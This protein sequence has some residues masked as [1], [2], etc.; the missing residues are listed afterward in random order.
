MQKFWKLLFIGRFVNSGC[1]ILTHPTANMFALQL[2]WL[3]LAF[4]LSVAIVLA[5][6]LVH[7]EWNGW[8]PLLQIYY[9]QLRW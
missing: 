4:V 9:V 3:T 6:C 2:V 8:G 7:D 1:D 5:L